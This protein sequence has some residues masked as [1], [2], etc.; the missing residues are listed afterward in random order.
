MTNNNNATY[1]GQP[2]P[3]LPHW[4]DCAICNP[5]K[6]T[7]SQEQIVSDMEMDRQ[8]ARDGYNPNR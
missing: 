4:R 1:P 6:V 3:H 5:P 7:R 2:C 8:A